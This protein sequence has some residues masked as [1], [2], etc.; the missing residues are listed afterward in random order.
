MIKIIVCIFDYLLLGLLIGL[1]N[2]N[3]FKRWDNTLLDNENL[4]LGII[5]AC[6]VLWPIVVYLIIDEKYVNYKKHK[7][8][9]KI[10]K[11]LKEHKKMADE[12]KEID[13]ELDQIKN[14]NKSPS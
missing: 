4:V 11:I 2:I 14:S 7:R 6:T 8:S 12:L 13:D 10:E 9:K 5:L 1:F 3:T